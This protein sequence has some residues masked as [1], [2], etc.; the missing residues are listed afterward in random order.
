MSPESRYQVPGLKLPASATRQSA[1]NRGAAGAR[2]EKPLGG[3]AQ[4]GAVFRPELCFEVGQ[5]VVAVPDTQGAAGVEFVLTELHSGAVEVD[6]GISGTP[7][8]L[9]GIED[10]DL[11]EDGLARPG[12]YVGRDPVA[13]FAE[14]TADLV[15]GIE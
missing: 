14:A 15:R 8:E 4:Q 13:G 6:A 2:P 9:G 5:A 12:Q 1:T 11:G 10:A 3:R 7:A